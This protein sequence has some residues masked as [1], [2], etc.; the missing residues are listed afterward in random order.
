MTLRPRTEDEH[1]YAVSS[2]LLGG[3]PFPYDLFFH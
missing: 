3:P 1:S 2:L